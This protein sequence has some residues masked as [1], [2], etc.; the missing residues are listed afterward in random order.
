[1]L[2]SEK[3]GGWQGRFLCHGTKRFIYGAKLKFLNKII[4]KQAF[5]LNIFVLIIIKRK[6]SKMGFKVY[7]PH[8]MPL[9]SIHQENSLVLL[10]I[11]F[12]KGCR[13][14]IL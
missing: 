6:I 7:D 12:Y 3:G 13:Y 14:N 9:L 8:A 4:E 5:I 11:I 2:L 10:F 1:M